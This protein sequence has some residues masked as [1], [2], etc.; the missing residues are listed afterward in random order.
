MLCNISFVSIIL[1]LLTLLPITNMADKGTQQLI[2]KDG[3][4]DPSIVQRHENDVNDVNSVAKSDRISIE[5]AVIDLNLDDL[6]DQVVIISS[7]LHSGSAGDSV[8]IYVNENG[9]EYRQIGT[10]VFQVHDQDTSALVAQF[11][12]SHQLK[13]GYRNIIIRQYTREIELE[14]EDGK[15]HVKLPE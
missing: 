3:L 15:Y 14:Y 8:Y 2:F 4:S 7:P 5:Y 12:V 10:F 6:L 11:F 9:S 13:G 1:T